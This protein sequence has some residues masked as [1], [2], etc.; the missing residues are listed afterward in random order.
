MDINMDLFRFFEI[1]MP[2][3]VAFLGGSGI[4]TWLQNRYNK[5]SSENELL[6]GVARCQIISLGQ[7]YIDRGYIVIDEYDDFYTSL[8]EPYI[9]LGGNGLGKRIFEE[10]EDLPMLPKGSDERKEK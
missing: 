4:W 9:K 10:V 3:L 7:Y 1:F 5:N 2:V 6:L 8:Y